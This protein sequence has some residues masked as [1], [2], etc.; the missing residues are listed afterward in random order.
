MEKLVEEVL[1][2]RESLTDN[3]DQFGRAGQ[4]AGAAELVMGKLNRA[5]V[6]ILR[7][8]D[9]DGDGRA[10]DLVMPAERSLFS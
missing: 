8:L 7:G 6:A 10:R 4:I 1:H 5:P 2:R 9:A 3:L